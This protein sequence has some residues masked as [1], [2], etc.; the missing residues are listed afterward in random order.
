[1]TFQTGDQVLLKVSHMKGFMRCGKK[2]KL[3]PRCI[4][5]FEILDG[6]G[7]VS[8]RRFGVDSAHDDMTVTSP[9]EKHWETLQRIL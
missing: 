9:K 4:V 1:M 2:D 6:V 8:Y 5:L 3:S 7:L